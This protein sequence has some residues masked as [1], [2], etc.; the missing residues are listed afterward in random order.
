MNHLLL[1]GKAF[2]SDQWSHLGAISI[3]ASSSQGYLAI[4]EDVF[5]EGNDNPLQYSC[6]ENPMDGGAWQAAVHGIA[7]SQTRLSDF[8]FTFHF[9]VIGEENGNPLQCSCLENSRDREAWWTAIYGVAQSR[10]QLKWL[11][12][13]SNNTFKCSLFVVT[14][15]IASI[16]VFPQWVTYPL[17]FSSGPFSVK[18]R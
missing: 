10:T 6:Q 13:S 12:S 7:K 8:T 18:W 17:S 2:T 9:H 5:R 1:R 4:S 3:S 15:C 14:E 11:S 16:Y